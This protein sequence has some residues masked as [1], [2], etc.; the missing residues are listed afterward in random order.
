MTIPVEKFDI[1]TMFAS[2]QAEKPT[3][4]YDKGWK[5]YQKTNKFDVVLVVE[6]MRVVSVRA[7]SPEQAEEI[8]EARTRKHNKN[9]EGRGYT[10]GDVHII[11]TKQV[12]GGLNER[13][14]R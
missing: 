9:F 2:R 1:T 6:Q 4:L 8:A 13:F 7:N 10:I 11:T 14:R 5:H 12:A 3:A